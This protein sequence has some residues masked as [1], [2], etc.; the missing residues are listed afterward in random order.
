MAWSRENVPGP[1][2]LHSQ[3][4]CCPLPSDGQGH[5][6]AN[7]PERPGSGGRAG[8]LSRFFEKTTLTSA[9]ARVKETG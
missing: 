8:K 9:V 5:A 4:R 3:V 7:L 2:L 1:A 6:Q